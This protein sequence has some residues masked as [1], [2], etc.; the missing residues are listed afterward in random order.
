MVYVSFLEDI[1]PNYVLSIIND[2]TE[3]KSNVVLQRLIKNEEF[4]K[5]QSE[6]AEGHKMMSV[7]HVRKQLNEK[8]ADGQIKK[9]RRRSDEN[10]ELQA[11]T[12]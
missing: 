11:N 2:K 10:I 7:N 4:F 3:M 12:K 1:V 9:Q 8:V 6:R 5:N